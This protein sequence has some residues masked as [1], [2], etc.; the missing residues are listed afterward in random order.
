MS[1]RPATAS[2]FTSST[3]A[4]GTLMSDRSSTVN[5]L[6]STVNDLGSARSDRPLPPQT[7]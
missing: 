5:V 2:V 4:T 3:I 7:Q 1:D 6:G